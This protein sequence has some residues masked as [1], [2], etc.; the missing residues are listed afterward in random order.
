MGSGLAK[1]FR[2]GVVVLGMVAAGALALKSDLRSSRATSAGQKLA[3]NQTVRSR[4]GQLPMVFE[5][6][7]GQTDAKVKFLAHG[8]SY[9]LFLTAD[10]AVLALHKSAKESIV[11]RMSLAGANSRAE[12]VGDRALPGKS[13]YLIGNDPSKWHRNI[14]QFAGVRYQDV[15][16]GVDLVYYGNQGRLEYDLEVQP[17]VNPHQIGVRFPGIEKLSLD[18][19]DLVI[20]TGQG[21]VRWQA[22][23][24]YQED[25]G[26]RQ[27]VTGKFVLRSANEVG[28]EVGNYDR[29]RKLVIDPLLVYSTYLGGTGN[30]ACSI[31]S[32]TGLVR[33]RCPA[34]AV[35][36]AANA[37]IAGATT[38]PT[39]PG[40]VAGTSFQSTLNGPANAFV[41]KLNSTGT[42]ILYSTYIGGNGSDLPGGIA[43]DSAFNADLV[44]TTTS[45]NFPTLNGFQDTAA[46]T[47]THAFVTQLNSIGTSLNYSTYLSGNGTD[48]GT[49]VALDFQ[50]KIYVTGTTTSSNFPV[51]PNPGAFQ[52]TAKA[53]NQFF[54]A[55]VNPT[56]AGASSLLYS[57]YIG[58]SSPSTG[59]AVGGGI[60]VDINTS[61]P[62][63]YVTG[64]TDFSDMPALN[65]FQTYL[66]HIDAWV[67]KFT[68]FPNQLN[69]PPVLSYLTYL[70]G[71][72][73]DDIGTGV[74]VDT[75]FNAYITGSTTS[76]DFMQAPSAAGTTP[77]QATN[78]G[79]MDAFVARVQPPTN[80]ACATASTACL[81]YFTYLGGSGN[82]AGTDI[83]LDVNQ[84]ARITGY[85]NSANFPVISPISNANGGSLNGAQDAFVARIDTTSAASGYSSSYLGGAGNDAGTG[86]AIDPGSNV[87]VAGETASANFPTLTPVQGALSGPSDAFVSKIG[88]SVAFAMTAV[89]GASQIGVG[90]QVSFTYTIMNTG[91]AASSVIFTDFVPASG[92]TFAGSSSNSCGQVIAGAVT[93]NLGFLN[94]Q[95]SIAISV[96]FIPTGAG[97][98]SN[99]A[100]VTAAGAN[101]VVA[102]ASASVSV[103]D[104]GITISPTSA[105][106][107]AGLP[108]VY[109]ITVNTSPQN[110]AIPNSIS[111]SVGAL[112]NGT[113]HTFSTN[114]IPSLATG[115]ATSTLTIGTTM[116]TTT[117]TERQRHGPIY[118][119]W[120]PVSGLAL[121][122]LGIGGKVSRRRKWLGG[123]IVA[124]VL[125]MAGLQAGCGSSS[126]SSRTTGT[127]AGTYVVTATA[128]SGTI[129]HSTSFTLVVQ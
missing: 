21:D 20:S 30:E 90:N 74:A 96:N 29:S 69:S 70:G 121:L 129:A 66:G 100:Q 122:G 26:K 9:G 89:A 85:T 64:G 84:G 60:A 126:Q 1:R 101:G 92:A 6:N 80:T 98:L 97:T 114:P 48:T 45:S 16:P 38:S 10:E 86:I 102:S 46:S 113:T 42:T 17:N 11:V 32:G 99:S 83:A 125:V 31:I 14:P 63:V 62:G 36:G 88:P 68:F 3:S 94:S 44:G 112:P 15:Y 109:T 57:T 111:L 34:I 87:Y 47:G 115:S 65:A 50:Q 33:P 124:A 104:F 72:T 120:F 43:V 108:A 56:F 71:M 5:P 13:N 51:F 18:R 77:L 35:D 39:F 93:C 52:L 27:A 119:V 117:I 24:V 95:Q 103:S 23:T 19:G 53:T 106:V 73:G 49:G 107:P 12:A 127:P 82:D 28:F 76:T 37:Y 123:L 91:D 7:H 22:P 128:T 81:L 55:S 118:A 105:T 8:G 110:S 2:V 75:S 58:G 61:T 54:M 67:A 59:V 116:R 4:F 79:G 40:V 41:T 25:Q 78:G